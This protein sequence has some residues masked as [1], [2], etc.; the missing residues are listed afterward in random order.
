M[1]D[2]GNRIFFQNGCS[3][4]R[5]IITQR[6]QFLNSNRSTILNEVNI[7]EITRNLDVNFKKSNTTYIS[8]AF[9]IDLNY[10]DLLIIIPSTPAIH[11]TRGKLYKLLIQSKIINLKNNKKLTSSLQNIEL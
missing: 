9:F 2:S 4:C 6:L 3:L 8:L 10:M 5:N 7:F 11:R 1:N